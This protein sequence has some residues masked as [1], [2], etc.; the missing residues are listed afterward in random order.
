MRPKWRTQEKVVWEDTMAHPC[1]TTTPE[2][3]VSYYFKGE[4]KVS[5]TAR[6]H[7]QKTQ[8]RVG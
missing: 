4:E 3:L 5:K 6:E 2:S 7:A 1:A 8:T